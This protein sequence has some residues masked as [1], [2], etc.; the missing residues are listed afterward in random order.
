MTVRGGTGD[1]GAS[2]QA[3]PWQVHAASAIGAGHLRD[4]R[5]NEDAIAHELTLPTEG[6]ALLVVGVADGHGDARHFRSDRG[7]KMAVAAGISATRDWAANISGNPARI[8]LSAQR[9]L[10]PGIVARW[11]AAVAADLADDQLT[12]P[13][14]ALLAD[15]ALSPQTAYGS[16]LLVGAFTGGY[17]VFTQIG[18]GNIVAVWPDGRSISPVPHDPG[19]DGIHTTSLCQ[20]DAAAAFRIGLI[21]LDA[22]P[23]FAVLLVTDGFGNAQVEDP[24]QPGVAAD[25]VRFGLDHDQS[26]FAS[27]VPGWA[28]Q[29]A[30]SAGSGDDST[31]ALVINSAARPRPGTPRAGSDQLFATITAPA[32][33]LE[34]A[35]P[36]LAHDGVEDQQ[37]EKPARDRST[38]EPDGPR[39]RPRRNRAWAWAAVTLAVALAGLVLAFMLAGSGQPSRGHGP[40]HRPSQHATRPSPSPPA[41]VGPSRQG[42][43]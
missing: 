34:L 17:A 40:R 2:V 36:S 28:E 8:K 30:S 39:P 18:D 20:P 23:L 10:V 16:T 42:R 33:T 19:L 31:I 3:L 15:L 35:M 1:S 4:G 6:S 32:R 12:V 22:R 9:E 14:H 13:E 27:Q 25:L 29:C 5:P 41:R 21:P 38:R 7:A 26:W 24:W 43:T 37:P 11:T